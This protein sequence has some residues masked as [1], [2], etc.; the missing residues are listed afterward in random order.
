MF[1]PHIGICLCHDLKR[2]IVVKAG[3]C[4]QGNDDIKRNNKQAKQKLL[5][6][7][8]EGDNDRQR[9]YDLH[10]SKWRKVDRAKNKRHNVKRCGKGDKKGNENRT[11]SRKRTG[12]LELF[13][14]IHEERDPWCEWCGAGISGFNVANYHHIKPKSKFP[15]LRLDKNNIVKI[16]FECHYKEHNVKKQKP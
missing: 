14:Q 9:I 2:L 8:V 10:K 16:C 11:N 7:G 3:L 5:P 6:G 15:E 4:K 13:R 12:E 1:K